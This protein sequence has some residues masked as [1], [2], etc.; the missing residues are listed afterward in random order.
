M[1][2]VKRIW[3]SFGSAC[4]NS[5]PVSFAIEAG[6]N[7]V[8]VISQYKHDCPKTFHFYTMEHALAYFELLQHS[9]EPISNEQF[10]E[11]KRKLCEAIDTTKMLESQDKIRSIDITDKRIKLIDSI[12]EWLY[13]QE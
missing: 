9:N 13:T 1:S 12:F 8:Q 3:A 11:L 5:E 2:E 4:I 6:S 10:A 7:S